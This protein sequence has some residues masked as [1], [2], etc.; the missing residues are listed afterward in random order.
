V[1]ERALAEGGSPGDDVRERR[2]GRVIDGYDTL[3]FLHTPD[4]HFPIWWT[5][6]PLRAPILVGWHGGPA[7]GSLAQLAMEEIEALAIA[8]LSKQFGISPK[9]MRDM[10]EAA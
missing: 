1:S 10:V 2:I 6:Y 5:G 8:S 9:K 4:D 7:A 3:S